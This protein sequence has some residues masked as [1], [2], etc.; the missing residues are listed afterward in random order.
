MELDVFLPKEKLAFEYQGENHFH[1]IY[2]L[3]DK[4]RKR[5]QDE[6]K[7]EA[8]VRKGITLVAVPYWWDF[9]PQSL[10][11]TIRQK[12]ESLLMSEQSGEPIPQLPPTEAKMGMMQSA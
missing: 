12:N 11:A 3:G 10:V 6:E 1:D 2:A 7:R 9:E 8:C 4:W 5:K